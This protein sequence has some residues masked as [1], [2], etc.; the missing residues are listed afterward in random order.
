MI[1]LTQYQIKMSQNNLKALFSN[2]IARKIIHAGRVLKYSG[3]IRKSGLF[4]EAYYLENN[5]DVRISGMHALKHYLIFGGFEG[6]KPS[7][8][9]DSGFYLAMY[10][11]VFAS[12]MNPLLHYILFGKNENRKIKAPIDHNENHT[13]DWSY[14]SWIKHYDTVTTEDLTNIR[15]T[16][17]TFQFKPLISV[18]MPVY[19]PE[20]DWLREA[21]D[22][23]LGQIY[24]YWELCIAD[25]C[26]T[27]PEIRS[28]LEY[29]QRFDARIKIVFRESNGHI[30]LASNSALDLVTGDYIAL[31]DHDDLLSAQA[32]YLA[33]KTINQ[34]PEVK[35][36]YSDEDKIDDHGN[37]MDP[38]F[39]C[40][41]NPDLLNAHN[42]FSHLGIYHTEL[43]NHVG[44][45][46]VGFEGS[47]DYDLVLRC[48]E[49]VTPAQIQH[50][51][52]VL[53]HWRVH[54]DSTSQF[55]D[56]KPYAMLA[57][58]RALNEHFARCNIRAE[59]QL[60]GSGYR[61]HYFLPVSP[62]LV[63]III[64]TRNGLQMLRPCI[65]SIHQLT[66][67]LN[68]EIIVVDNGSD[69]ADTLRY[70]YP[71]DGIETGFRVLR[72]DQPFNY[73]ALNNVAVKEAKGEYI[74]TLNNDVSVISPDW[75]NELMGLA[76][77]PGVGAV[78][79]KLYYP[80]DTVQ[81]AGIILGLG[82][83]RVAGCAH[84]KIG[85][86]N[87]GYF[88]RASLIN[89]FSAVT[90]ACMVVKKSIY[91]AV[92]GFNEIDLPISYNDVDFC[93][94][95][96]EA[97]YRNVFNPFAELYHHESFSRGKEIKPDGDGQFNR[98][99]DYMRKHWGHVLLSDPA[100]NPN[101][102]LD[103][104]DFRLAWP[105]RSS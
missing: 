100:Y 41:W 17:D 93:L 92:N 91:E 64:L 19:N 12:G 2:V 88:G 21:I 97:G 105:P 103:S 65:R 58:E 34:N 31:L 24:P 68:Y 56:N 38:Y 3:K 11:D 5:A 53:Y 14:T 15:D 51:P 78:G 84:N 79:A 89:S 55:A 63:S 18:V 69:D 26:S 86:D 102:S 82:V 85:K 43:V 4:D 20:P 7:K 28:I 59:A 54:K 87:M 6:R 71:S 44:R 61:I 29:Y 23:V 47:Q 76:I 27:N 62:P 60:I 96:M 57:G 80:D 40:D 52:Q 77:Q 35:L 30:S 98:E 66:R 83:H 45:F 25:D 9:F 72:I 75:L 36:I 50:I 22:S 95:L 104:S 39:K 46:R 101:L 70:L 73:S 48:T 8:D 49:A 67:Y 32:L 90:A 16:I 94:R 10:E 74:A 99:I 1:D 37:R 42:L 13:F 33:S 81:H